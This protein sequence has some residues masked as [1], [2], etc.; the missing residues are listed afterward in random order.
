MADKKSNSRA[1]KAVNDTKKKT[2]NPTTTVKKKDPAEQT[3]NKV[4]SSVAEKPLIP[5]RTLWAV[6]SLV[7]FVLFLFTYLR[8]SWNPLTARQNIAT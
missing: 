5:G 8:G 3:G 1:L 7:L 6:I 2:G 4:K